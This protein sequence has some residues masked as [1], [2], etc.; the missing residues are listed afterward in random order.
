MERN[1]WIQVLDLR[2]LA[3]PKSVEA[4]ELGPEGGRAMRDCLLRS[5]TL[6]ELDLGTHTLSP[7]VGFNQLG[8]E[9]CK[10]I[11]EALC[12]NKTLRKLGMRISLAGPP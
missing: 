10:S 3:W 11:A 9:G 12:G 2:I 8:P 4:N 1:R 5:T 7:L 6:I